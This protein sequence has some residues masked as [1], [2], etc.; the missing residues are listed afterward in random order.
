VPKPNRAA[1]QRARARSRARLRAF[2][3]VLAYA[4]LAGLFLL[5][6]LRIGGAFL[7]RDLL[8]FFHPWQS[9]VAAT[10]RTGQLPFWNH[11]TLCG[12]PLL[13]NLQAGVLYPP[14]WLYVA[15][16]FDIAL[17]A[18][19]AFHLVMA[20]A[21][22]RGFLRR[23][24]L[25]QPAAFAGGL[26]FGFG[27]WSISYLEFPM[28]L[29]AAIWLPLLWSGLWDA[30][31]YHDRRG[32][33]LGGIAIAL[34][35]L[36]GYPQITFLGLLSAA[37]LAIALAVPVLREK[38][39]PASV[40]LLRLGALVAMLVLGILVAAIQLV[41]AATM[42]ALSGK[43]TPYEASVALTRS[44]PP[45]NLLGLIDPFLFGFPGVDRFWGGEIVEFCF[46]AMFVG[47]IGLILAFASAPAFL[48]LRRH[49]RVRKEDLER[50]MET[51]IV[52]R[53]IPFFL[54]AGL[55]VGI[56]LALGRFTPLYP[57]LHDWAPGFGR[58]RWPAT[59]CYLIAVHLAALA[60][61][62][63]QAL[64]RDPRRYVPASLAALG[65][66][67][68]LLVLWAMATGPLAP[69]LGDFLLSGAPE[70]QRAAWDAAMPDWR[71][72][73]LPRAALPLIAGLLGLLL[74]RRTPHV[75]TM[76][77]LLVAADLFLASR[78]LETPAARGFYD[79]EPENAVAVREQLGGKRL[80]TPRSVDQLG[81]FLYGCR[82]PV[83][84][85]WAKRAMLCNANVPCGV[86]QA[87]GCEPL[88]PRRH[89]AFSQAFDSPQTPHEIRERIFDLWDA[90]ALMEV[91][92]VRPLDIPTLQDPTAGIRLNP[93]TPGL[94]RV[95]VL[96][97][98]STMAEPNELLG[99]L[100]SAE[101]DP[102]RL[103]LLEIPEGAAPPRSA[104]QAPSGR[105]EVV[106]WARSPNRITAAW[107]VGDGG[108]MRVL[109][110]WDPGWSATVNG[111]PVPVYRADFAFLAVP[112]P[113]GSVEVELRYRPEG[114]HLGLAG[115]G[116]GLL[117]LLA[118]WLAERTHRR[119][120]NTL[121]AQEVVS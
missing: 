77:I 84:F 14:N 72:T 40:R 1:I 4:G 69:K 70:F 76:W 19:M 51:P 75:A 64:V 83:A 8:T 5:D 113:A 101:H 93:H 26:L 108:M 104:E 33:G 102:A 66:G 80:Y 23:I 65:L 31:V 112:V 18:G 32:L 92:G 9:A 52:P 46:G 117:G 79:A 17:T 74:A 22:M 37:I 82:N 47:G 95:G 96:S 86:A 59:A 2:L 111:E 45:K 10:L 94:G 27:M 107:H 87:N 35:L 24:D 61:V 106:E 58:S 120:R 98:W 16:P 105:V 73:L 85:D 119:H 30:M 39:L 62:G 114:W 97:G 36:A 67:A 41:P 25:G 116:L 110:T 53:V 43:A 44:L 13:A 54:L 11:D 6:A 29:G 63:V 118:C 7:L 109:E 57:M 55:L 89:D 88:G 12:V 78:A 38:K 81:N 3:A 56:V 21:L 103:T 28:K 90:G 48:K 71:S 34:S 60:A 100:L 15:L 68:L 121:A 49:R 115:S 50:P 42:T 99:R 91:D 20:A